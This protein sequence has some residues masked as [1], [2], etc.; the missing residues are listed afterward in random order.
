MNLEN[1]YIYPHQTVDFLHLERQSEN[2]A[3]IYV[4]QYIPTL[5]NNSVALITFDD[6]NNCKGITDSALGYTFSVYREKNN[7]NKLE[8]ITRISEGT[9]SLIDYN[10]ANQNNYL[11]YVFKEDKD[12]ISAANTSNLV[13]TCW[14]NWSIV[15]L[16]KSEDGNYYVD[17]DNIWLFNLNVE[18]ADTTHN[19]SKTEYQ[20]LTRYPKI[21]MGKMNYVSGS[22]TCLLGKISNNKYYEP[23]E[24][25]DAWRNFCVGGEV[26]LLRD[27]KGNSL[28][29]EIVSESS[30]IMDETQEQA[31]TITFSWTQVNSPEGMTIMEEL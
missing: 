22:L 10:V 14:W 7:S 12:Y 23:T 30:N 8:Y 1:I 18:S 13:R 9:L 11:Y 16:K 6:T 25:T 27:R 15:G 4:N 31:R 2:N 21:S 29:V 28:I 20:N 19:F 17:T 26:K 24:M 5:N 3:N